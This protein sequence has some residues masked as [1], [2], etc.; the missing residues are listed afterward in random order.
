MV[1]NPRSSPD[2]EAC[3]TWLQGLSQSGIAIAIPEIADYEVRRELLRSEKS[4]GL[5]RLDALKSL[6]RFVPITSAAML[7]PAEFRA[8]ARNAG[9]QSASDSSLDADMIL[10]GP[11]RYPQGPW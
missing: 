2:S 9:W 7:K 5:A 10:C 3:K 4:L 6:L 1:T 11:G 8:S